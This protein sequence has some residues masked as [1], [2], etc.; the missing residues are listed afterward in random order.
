MPWL[1]FAVNPGGW[2][3]STTVCTSV[4]AT[5]TVRVEIERMFLGIISREDG[6]WENGMSFTKALKASTITC[7]RRR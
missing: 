2:V 5:T 1:G 3:A 6:K 7:G 4:G